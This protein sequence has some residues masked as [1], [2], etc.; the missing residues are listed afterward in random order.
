MLCYYLHRTCH[1]VFWTDRPVSGVV[2]FSNDIEQEGSVTNGGLPLYRR[3]MLYNFFILRH[4][5]LLTVSIDTWYD[6]SVIVYYM[7]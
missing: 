1:H 6:T 7:V 4:I 2:R 3:F 5:K